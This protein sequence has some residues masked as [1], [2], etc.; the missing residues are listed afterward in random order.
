MPEP[1]A[2]DSARSPGCRNV[3]RVTLGFGIWGLGFGIEPALPEFRSVS[4]SGRARAENPSNHH[5]QDEHAG[6]VD[7]MR[8]GRHQSAILPFILPGALFSVRVHV[9]FVVH[10]PCSAFARVTNFEHRT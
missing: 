7:E 10:L 8:G 4:I 3:S 2:N 1:R 6:D 5:A 9:R